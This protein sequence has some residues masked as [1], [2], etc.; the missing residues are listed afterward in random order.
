VRAARL[1]AAT[2]LLCAGL[3]A[4]A[5]AQG[6]DPAYRRRLAR[7]PVTEWNAHVAVQGA[8]TPDGRDA[9]LAIVAADQGA[10]HLEGRWNYEAPGAVAAF[11]GGN[12]TA[13]NDV[14]VALTPMLGVT[15]GSLGA[16]VPALEAAVAWRSFDFYVEAEWVR[17]LRD[18]EATVFYAWSELGYMP[19]PGL[20]T[21][22]VAE[23]SR[24]FGSI[25]D[26]QRGLFLQIEAG[27]L[28]LGAFVFSPTDVS[29]RVTV[30]KVGAS[31]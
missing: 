30:F 17:D 7:A 4:E 2:L 8:W 28:T 19:A 20:R 11:V 21:G 6:L 25:G 18:R 10:L 27:P 5:L 31:F 3:A 1:R 16:I 24:R 26:V 9:A 29:T 22:L 23:R 13:G 14:R 12:W 15:G